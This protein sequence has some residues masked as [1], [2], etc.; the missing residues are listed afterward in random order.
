MLKQNS[1]PYFYFTENELSV[2]KI[3][4]FMF[5]IR[6]HFS[7]CIIAMDNKLCNKI[8]LLKNY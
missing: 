5:F 8:Y 1:T 3:Y 4:G 6:K 2:I 7:F